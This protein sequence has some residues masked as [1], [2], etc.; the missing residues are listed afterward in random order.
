M[1]KTAYMIDGKIS[2]T[3]YKPE[4]V[5]FKTNKAVD[6][7]ADRGKV[8]GSFK[9]NIEARANIMNILNSIH[10][11]KNH[12]KLPSVDYQA[13]NDIVIKLVR[14]A[15]TPEHIDSWRDTSLYAKL[16]LERLGGNINSED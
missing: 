16:N 2:A 8:Y 14:L 15:A 13:L 9:V 5:A 12:S 4:D 7:L 10:S 11:D 3:Q 6:I 1:N